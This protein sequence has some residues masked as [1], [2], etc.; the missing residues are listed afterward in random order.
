[1]AFRIDPNAQFRF[2]PIRKATVALPSQQQQFFESQ[3]DKAVRERADAGGPNQLDPDTEKTVV[4][5]EGD[6]LWSIAEESNVDFADILAAN[7]GHL[8]ANGD[9]IH[10]NEVIIVPESAPE[11]VARSP[12]GADGAPAGESA[13]LDDL[14]SRGNKL[15]YQ[16]GIS[17]DELNAGGEAIKKDV[18]AYLD[19]LPAS[20]RQTAALRIM[21]YDWSDGG[22]AKS[23]AES[24]IRERGL[25]T[26]PEEAFAKEL[27]ERG[28]KGA[29]SDDPNYDFAAE[30]KQL[31]ADTK[32]YLDGLPEPD[33]AAALQRLF[34]RDWTDGGPALSALQG[35]GK[36][37]GIVLRPSGHAGPQVE[38]AARKI[39]DDAGTAGSPG[40]AFKKLADGYSKATPEVKQ[41]IINSQDVRPL[42]QAAADDATQALKNY[43]PKKAVSDQGDAAEVMYNLRSLVDKADPEL[44]ARLM[45]AALPTIEA[46]NV[47]RQREVG[48]NL[49]GSQGL[50]DLMRITDKMGDAPGASAVVE[51]FAEMGCYNSNSIPQAI[52]G[53]S[54]LDYPLA[55]GLPIDKTV[56][57]YVQQFASGTVNRDVDAYLEHTKELQYLIVNKGPLMTPDQLADAIADYKKAEGPQWQQKEQELASKIQED[58]KKLLVQI[59]QLGHLPPELAQDQKHANDVIAKLLGDD[60][61]AMALDMTLTKEP[62]L[63]SLPRFDTLA[64]TLRLTDRGRKIVEEVATQLIRRTVIPSFADFDPGNAATFT[65]VQDALV[66]FKDGSM[67][68]MLGIKQNDLDKAV[69]LVEDTLPKAGDTPGDIERKMRQLNA[70]LNEITD[71]NGIKAFKNDT[72]S[73]KILRIIGTAATLAGLVNSGVNFANDPTWKGGLK[74]VIDTAGV[75]QR[76]IELSHGFGLL[77]GS[78]K[79]VE[80]FGSSSKPAVKILGTVGAVFDVWNAVDYFK[81][82]DPTMGSLSLVAGGGT[83]MAALGTGTAFGPIGLAVVIG[84]VIAQFVV[85]GNRDHHEFETDG[86]TAFLR[87]AGLSEDAAT[88]LR[89]QSREGYSP[90]PLLIE[91]GELKGFKMND[92]ASRQT[93]IDWINAMPREALDK[94]VS[95]LHHTLA[96]FKGDASKLTPTASSDSAYTD[97]SRFNAKE[98]FTAEG[99]YGAGE[100]TVHI[101]N[102]ASKVRKGE[103]DPVSVAQIDVALRALG[104]SI[105]VS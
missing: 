94:L 14:Y 76:A 11:L 67:A 91:Y 40:E 102:T 36:D 45:Q 12:V 8:D 35:A 10:P 13:F 44:A 19:A 37:L 73:G 75:G 33:R 32:A 87:H 60:K 79:S 53:G 57:P 68:N 50:L 69:K 93:F 97:P 3:I 88:A 63:L 39:I 59:D 85:A 96:G 86:A 16:D 43:D 1:M 81:A 65:K 83:V 41:A 46:A 64:G 2:D 100:V 72:T 34:D 66:A 84:A 95:N 7:K 38:G 70:G 74:M 18:G 103:A 71:A 28:S 20:E 101:D 105:P 21:A 48:T 92:P 22:P 99:D 6:S 56:T 98:D 42:I 51:G 5:E 26:D 82:G 31:T 25:E 61:T 49:I 58:G 54:R 78:N 52:A 55:L 30:Q 17:L 77:S 89:N 9:M 104:I 4:V 62:S 15:G 47:T 90:V 29:D 27:Y 24:A 80:V 23:S